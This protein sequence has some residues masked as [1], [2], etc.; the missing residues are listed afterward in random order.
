MVVSTGVALNDLVGA[1]ALAVKGLEDLAL[2]GG[3]VEGV[4][5]G[6]TW[7]YREIVV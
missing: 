3:I 1:V 5:V 2:L 7:V 6:I 4:I